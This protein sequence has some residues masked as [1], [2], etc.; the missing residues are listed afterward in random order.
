MTLQSYSSRDFQ[1]TALSANQNSSK[2]NDDS[3]GRKLCHGKG[4]NDFS[5]D[6]REEYGNKKSVNGL[7][8]NTNIQD[9]LKIIAA[10]PT[11]SKKGQHPIEFPGFSTK[12]KCFKSPEDTEMN[13]NGATEGKRVTKEPDLFA[14]VKEL[15]TYKHELNKN[16]KEHNIANAASYPP[17]KVDTECLSKNSTLSEHAETTNTPHESN[18]VETLKENDS[19]KSMAELLEEALKFKKQLQSLI[20]SEREKN[21]IDDV[22]ARKDNEPLDYTDWLEHEKHFQSKI[23]DMIT[24]ESSGSSS[25]DKSNKLRALRPLERKSSPK[26]NS[27]HSGENKRENSE[28]ELLPDEFS[29]ESRVLEPEDIG[30]PDVVYDLVKVDDSNE[31]ASSTLYF[32]NVKPEEAEQ[33]TLETLENRFPGK[34]E[35]MLALSETSEKDI[36]SLDFKTELNLN[37]LSEASSETSVNRLLDRLIESERKIRSARSEVKSKQDLATDSLCGTVN[38]PNFAQ[39]TQPEEKPDHLPVELDAEKLTCSDGNETVDSNYEIDGKDDA[40]SE[41]SGMKLTECNSPSSI[42]TVINTR[43]GNVEDSKIDEEVSDNEEESGEEQSNQQDDSSKNA[44]LL[45]EVPIEN[46][47]IVNKVDSC[48]N[49]RLIDE[50]AVSALAECY[51]NAASDRNDKEAHPC[52]NSEHENQNTS[53]GIHES[54]SFTIISA[55][56]DDTSA[57]NDNLVGDVIIEHSA[58]EI[59]NITNREDANNVCSESFVQEFRSKEDLNVKFCEINS[60]E[61]DISQSGEA[62]SSIIRSSDSLN[63]AETYEV[64]ETESYANLCVLDTSTLEANTNLENQLIDD[65]SAIESGK[66]KNAG[67]TCSDDKSTPEE[68]QLKPDMYAKSNDTSEN[69]TQL[70]EITP[71]VALSS[72]IPDNAKLNAHNISEIKAYDDSPTFH[73][74]SYARSDNLVEKSI[75]FDPTIQN[76]K[77]VSNKVT[78]TVCIDSQKPEPQSKESI[79]TKSTKKNNTLE[80][81][82]PVLESTNPPS[83]PKKPKTNN[84][85]NAAH[86][87]PSNPH[88][89]SGSSNPDQSS[90]RPHKPTNPTQRQSAK[91][92]FDSSNSR[93]LRTNSNLNLASVERINSAPPHRRS[94]SFVTPRDMSLNPR[95]DRAERKN[96]T[97]S[98]ALSSK[99]SS[100]SRTPRGEHHEQTRKFGVRRENSYDSISLSRSQHRHGT[101]GGDDEDQ[102]M[103]FERNNSFKS[104]SLSSR[105]SSR[106]HIMSTPRDSLHEDACQGNRED[107]GRKHSVESLSSKSSSK[108][109][110]PVL[111][112]RLEALRKTRCETARAKSPIRTMT[113]GGTSCSARKNESENE[114]FCKSIEGS[115][116]TPRDANEFRFKNVIRKS[117]AKLPEVSVKPANPSTSISDS[118]DVSAST[119]GSKTNE[120]RIFDVPKELTKGEYIELLQMVNENPDF[121]KLPNMGG[122]YDKLGLGGDK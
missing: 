96:S 99:S 106:S 78:D 48:S 19:D 64:L 61:K 18:S 41:S 108:S 75:N 98:L 77:I 56:D 67:D 21:N 115:D 31:N 63:S 57:M 73:K 54:K 69:D 12:S 46:F 43:A 93:Q 100:R 103:K 119:I 94:K 113:A 6:S 107:L 13:E 44:S 88:H 70:E 27:E 118:P 105:S 5:N 71:K 37:C 35:A 55:S 89:P 3:I 20:K 114:N 60:H 4:N 52:E 7:K 111:R 79:S 97:E 65:H 50:N 24:E 120:F 66:A 49:E 26:E 122:F 112:N 34:L 14:L 116:I 30:V 10:Y 86:K 72:D 80:N 23:L 58:I 82:S 17:K 38:S 53:T 121:E 9:A 39:S 81:N 76:Q 51:E 29:T 83:N 110:I 91:S 68:Y 95:N 101:P 36:D 90:Q 84:P 22:N 59:K 16:L 74:D 40:R 87:S 62:N 11:M 117:S 1:A 8:R 102:G 92:S 85:P 45:T 2:A 15:S 104:L 42:S 109:C 47:E 32:E 33:I 28:N 25:T